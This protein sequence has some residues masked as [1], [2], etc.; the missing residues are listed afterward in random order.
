MHQDWLWVS[1][2]AFTAHLEL[3]LDYQPGGGEFVGSTLEL[4]GTFTGV[5]QLLAVRSGLRLTDRAV[6]AGV[7]SRIGDPGAREGG[8]AGETDPGHRRVAAE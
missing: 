7:H 6:W 4:E 2:A 3:Q 8:R 1:F 5:R